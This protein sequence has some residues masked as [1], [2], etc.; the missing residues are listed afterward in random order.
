MQDAEQDLY[1][2]LRD[3]GVGER[4]L[5]AMA[6]V[7]RALFTT[8]G[9]GDRAYVN[10]PLPIPAGQTISQPYVVARMCE[11]LALRGDERV[12]DVG[13]GSGWH[14]AVLAR[15][16]RHVWSIERHPVLS[17]AADRN[18]RGCGV[19][20]VTLLVGDG[21][22]GHP[23]EAPYD[24]INVAAGM[25]RRIPPALERQLA[26]GGRIVAPVDDRLVVERRDGDILRHSTHEGVRFVPL[27]SG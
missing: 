23:A 5:G 4:V 1:E 7:P 19:D 12:L 15:L 10:E 20:N 22:L 3:R 13:T 14:A 18:L 8:V 6:S 26:D 24:A 25:R 17:R 21:A 2:E 11:M 16:A 9:T 27:V